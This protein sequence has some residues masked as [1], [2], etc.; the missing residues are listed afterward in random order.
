MVFVSLTTISTLLSLEHV[1]EKMY[2]LG[3]R[4]YNWYFFDNTKKIKK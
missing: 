2:H 4:L 1:T 3:F